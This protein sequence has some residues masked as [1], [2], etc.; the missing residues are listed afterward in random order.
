M[1][2]KEMMI[3]MMEDLQ[4]Q[5][6]EMEK[7]VKDMLE[8]EGRACGIEL[9]KRKNARDL[10]E[11]LI[12][13]QDSQDDAPAMTWA[14]VPCQMAEEDPNCYPA[15][16]F[17][18]AYEDHAEVHIEEEACVHVEEHVIESEAPADVP[19]EEH[20]EPAPAEEH[21]EPAPV[22][23]VEPAPAEEHV[24]APAVQ[25]P[26]FDASAEAPAEDPNQPAG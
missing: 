20:V 6:S 24:E 13:H 5:A 7:N 19:V 17:D 4:H 11:Q 12:E 9:D 23:H 8:Q 1:Y 3:Q 15:D 18:H 16:N 26:G 21:V 25:E 14:Y 10:M 2:D 22:E